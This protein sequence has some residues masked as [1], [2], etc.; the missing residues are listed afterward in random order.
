LHEENTLPNS[1]ERTRERLERLARLIRGAGHVEG[2]IPAQWDVLRYLARA[3]RFS[4]APIAVA[5]YLGATKGTISQSVHALIRKD[6][7]KSEIRGSDARSVALSLT[8][9]GRDVLSRDPLGSLGTDL[10]DLP[11]KTTKHFGRAMS[12]L[13]GSESKRQGLALFG[14]CDSCRLFLSGQKPACAGFGERLSH[15]D[16]SKLC[17]KFRP[18]KIKGQAKSDNSN[19]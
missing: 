9:K 11:D 6:L 12:K 17:C 13:L 16:I 7:V 18:A 4:N 2:L 5:Q 14:S 1:T 19:S 10:A 8:E 3:N 15:D